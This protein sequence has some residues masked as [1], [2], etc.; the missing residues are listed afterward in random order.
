MTYEQFHISINNLKDFF[1]ELEKLNTII[2][3][4]SPS[5]TG[6]CEIGHKFIEDYISLVESNLG[7]DG[8][9]VSWFVFDNNFGNKKLQCYYKDIEYV[10]S[11]DKEMFE[12]IKLIQ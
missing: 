11:N 12:F 7:D 8:G 6:V 5:G 9:F 10:I 4:L 2:E 1:K 3:I